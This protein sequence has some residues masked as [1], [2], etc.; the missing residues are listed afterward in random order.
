LSDPAP[1][2]TRIGGGLSART[3]VIGVAVT[4]IAVVGVAFVNRPPALPPVTNVAVAPTPTAST[5]PGGVPAPTDAPLPRRIVRAVDFDNAAFAV[6]ALIAGR[7]Y[8][9][10]L[11]KDRDGNLD[12]W[13][14]LP[15]PR[16]DNVGTIELAQL[17]SRSADANFQS[18]GRWPLPLD[19]LMPELRSSGTVLSI[20]QLG[21]PLTGENALARDGFKLE[22]RLE[23]RPAYGMLFATVTVDQSH[24]RVYGEDGI[25]GLPG[26]PWRAND[27][28]PTEPARLII[29]WLGRYWPGPGA[30]LTR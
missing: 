9:V 15:Y 21:Q 17:W 6:I 24:H 20:A 23:S 2:T 3:A 25:F 30:K 26:W 11:E 10:L 28:A 12:G 8:Q 7:Q 14:R 13:A 5:E 29:P 22:I 19:L 4:L 27:T 1:A 18:I 16:A